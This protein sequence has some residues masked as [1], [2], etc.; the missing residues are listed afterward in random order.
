MSAIR[1]KES[2]IIKT[3]MRV[4]LN[5]LAEEDGVA[6]EGCTPVVFKIKRGFNG[7][8]DEDMIALYNKDYKIDGW[9]HLDEQVESKRGRWFTAT[10]LAKYIDI[11]D[12]QMIIGKD[13][14]FKGRNLK[15]MQC[16]ILIEVD[17]NTV[18]VEL[19]EDVGGC[20]A[21]GFGK[22]GHCIVVNKEILK[23]VTLK[24]KEK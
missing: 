9:G 20:S 10:E 24:Q 3:G 6:P 8:F 23:K 1:L 17:P 21:D 5:R 22:T 19:G 13:L 14:N 15:G 18:F 4:K 12:V 11:S 2:V 7:E 16:Q